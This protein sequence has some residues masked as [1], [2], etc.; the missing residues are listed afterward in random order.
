[1][2]ESRIFMLRRVAS[3]QL[4]WR[5]RR[6]RRVKVSADKSTEVR[7]HRVRTHHTRCLAA[8]NLP[9]PCSLPRLLATDGPRAQIQGSAADFAGA[10]LLCSSRSAL[11]PPCM[12][13]GQYR[14]PQRCRLRCARVCFS[15]RHAVGSLVSPPGPSPQS[16]ALSRGSGKSTRARPPPNDGVEEK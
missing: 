1:M 6:G 8:R 2:I 10:A 13:S 7:A 3:R 5:R 16:D 14:R 11:P 15:Y 9:F 12:P 4:Q